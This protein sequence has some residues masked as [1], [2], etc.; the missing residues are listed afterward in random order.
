MIP[1]VGQ[2]FPVLV[3]SSKCAFYF[4]SFIFKQDF[5]V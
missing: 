3:Y 4:P 5:P 1:T 2:G